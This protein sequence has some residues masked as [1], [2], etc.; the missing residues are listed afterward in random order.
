MG[1]LKS[2]NDSS[3][4]KIIGHNQS[5]NGNFLIDKGIKGKGLKVI[6]IND[7]NDSTCT[8]AEVAKRISTRK[9]INGIIGHYSSIITTKTIS[10]YKENNLAFLNVENARLSL[11]YIEG[12]TTCGKRTKKVNDKSITDIKTDKEVDAST[13]SKSLLANLRVNGDFGYVDKVAKELET[14]LNKGDEGVY[15][16]TSPQGGSI[17]F[18]D[19]ASFD[20]FGHRDAKKTGNQTIYASKNSPDANDNTKM[21]DADMKQ[22]NQYV[23]NYQKALKKQGEFPK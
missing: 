2:K 21:S 13:V 3:L 12:K 7:A 4:V 1:F 22:Y 23:K 16:R 18:K 8:A 20:V 15:K 11:R 10:I 17:T 5:L 9:D 19:G 14:R 6:V